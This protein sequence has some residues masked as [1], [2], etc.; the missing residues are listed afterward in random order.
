LLAA[1]EERKGEES[2]GNIKLEVHRVVDIEV[3]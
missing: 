3:I 1:R 2:A